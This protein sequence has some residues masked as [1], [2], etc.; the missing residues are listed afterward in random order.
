MLAHCHRPHGPNLGR[1]LYCIVYAPIY[2]CIIAY[3]ILIPRGVMYE[4]H[5]VPVSLGV[6]LVRSARATSFACLGH[7]GS[8][9]NQCTRRAYVL[10]CL[11]VG[12]VVRLCWPHGVHCNVDRD[13]ALT[14]ALASSPSQQLRRCPWKRS[15]SSSSQVCIR[16]CTL[17]TRNRH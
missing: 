5:Q 7:P 6:P 2:K 1:Q 10:G 15:P 17:S 11:G 12:V 13:G 16:P 4:Q 9:M 3:C 14:L 8:S